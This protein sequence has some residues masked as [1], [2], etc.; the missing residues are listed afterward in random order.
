MAVIY[1]TLD[2]ISKDLFEAMKDMPED[3][4]AGD[5]LASDREMQHLSALARVY[6]NALHDPPDGVIGVGAITYAENKLVDF[7]Q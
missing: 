1:R 2:D 6:F 4:S 7:Q 3:G 5:W